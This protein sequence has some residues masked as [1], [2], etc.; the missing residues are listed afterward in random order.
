MHT[1]AGE[2]DPPPLSAVFVTVSVHVEVVTS[3]E[4]TVLVAVASAVFATV[5]YCVTKVVLVATWLREAT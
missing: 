2:V 3:V 5:V 1:A 4:K